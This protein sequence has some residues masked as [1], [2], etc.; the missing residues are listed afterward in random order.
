MAVVVSRPRGCVMEERYHPIGGPRNKRNRPFARVSTEHT[1]FLSCAVRLASVLPSASYSAV[2]TART[3]PTAAKDRDKNCGTRLLVHYCERWTFFSACVFVGE[4]AGAAMRTRVL[5]LVALAWFCSAD[6]TI[7]VVLGDG[8]TQRL[9]LGWF[10]R[11]ADATSRLQQVQRLERR[12]RYAASA[13]QRSL[14]TRSAASSS[15]GDRPSCRI[16]VATRS[17]RCSTAS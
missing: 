10:P 7:P 12:L 6:D 16:T 5:R 13:R 15:R 1:A 9:Q 14:A 2:K 11:D 8:T 4:E 3:R 17:S